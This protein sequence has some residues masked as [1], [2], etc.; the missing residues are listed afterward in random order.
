MT[1]HQL[2]TDIFSRFPVIYSNERMKWYILNSQDFKAFFE[3]LNE[4]EAIL[5]NYKDKSENKE[6]SDIG[7]G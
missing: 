3:L 4:E 5:K 2:Y 7:N 1:C 6:K